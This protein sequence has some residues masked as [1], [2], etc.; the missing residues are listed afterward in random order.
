MSRYFILKI[1]LRLTLI[2][3]GALSA[4]TIFQIGYPIT[5]FFVILAV[6]LLF[7]E[8]YFAL[9]RPFSEIQKTLRSM[10]SDDYSIQMSTQNKGEIFGI[11]SQ[12]YA[13]QRQA[14]F[15]QES[16]K[17]I[18]D[19][20][21][22]GISSGVLI[23][24]KSVENDWEIFLMNAAFSDIFQ[25]PNFVSWKNLQR[26]LPK[27]TQKLEEIG[28]SAVQQTLEISVDH[29]EKQT[30]SLKTSTIQT[31]NY[32]YFTVL[33]DSVQSIVEKKEKQAWADLMQVMA[34]ELMNTLT[35]I[36]SLVN[37]LQYYADKKEWDREDEDD[38]N[39][40]LKTIQKKTLQ[41]LTFVDNYRQ[42]S[43]FPQAKKTN[44]ELVH[45][46]NKTVEMMQALADKK[47]ISIQISA[48]LPEIFHEIDA[49]LTEHVLVN[50]I[51]N[52]FHALEKNELQPKEIK[53]RIGQKPTRTFIEISDNGMGIDP[54]IRD[55]IFIPFFTT[56]KDGAGIGL[57][58]SKNIM[59]VQ[60]GHLTFKSKA[61]ETVFVMSFGN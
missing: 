30:F 54:L 36:N 37:N 25:I 13:K 44:V 45:W 22:N 7:V 2:C 60:N 29:Q 50:L 3:I 16:V 1:V 8:L 40:S 46:T 57:S 49:V 6:F 43:Q 52:S 38:F 18:Y 58:L 39:E 12:V 17:L 27:F 48:D 59:E 11:L 56:R 32:S 21:F 5:S 41:M 26:N 35:P 55:K 15:E 34:H 42:L 20:L 14:Y 61:G 23:L 19:N 10:L 4:F 9:Y 33:L 53:I 47:G 28:F 31:Y 24:R 51:T